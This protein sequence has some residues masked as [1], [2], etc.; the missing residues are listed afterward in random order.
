MAAPDTSGFE[1]VTLAGFSISTT[2]TTST[3]TAISSSKQLRPRCQL[4]RWWL[5]QTSPGM[6]STFKVGLVGQLLWHS[7]R[8]HACRAKLFRSW[9]PFLPGPGLFFFSFYPSV[10]YPQSGPSRRCNTT[11]FPLEMDAWLC[12]LRWNSIICSELT[13]RLV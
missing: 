13:K 11:N 6:L 2:M 3:N 12:S 7:G 8:A 4:P 9:V 1:G 5:Q 10:V